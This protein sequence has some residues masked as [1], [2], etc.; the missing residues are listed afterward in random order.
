[1]KNKSFIK[2]IV[3][4]ILKNILE[5]IVLLLSLLILLPLYMLVVNSF[6]DKA[7]AGNMSLALPKVWD[8]IDNYKQVFE[9]GGLLNAFK[10][11]A[12]I[13]IISIV[14]IV[15]ISSIS[16]FIIQRRKSFFTEAI[17]VIIMIIMVIPV[18]IVTVFFVVMQ[19]HLSGTYIGVSL[20]YATTFIP[21]AIFL[22]VG[23]FKS[24]PREIDES[25]WLDGC[26]QIRLFY[27]LIFPLAQPVTVTVIIISFM[28]IWND[29]S[30]VIYMFD[31]PQK[32]TVVLTTFFFYSQYISSWNLVFAD[33][34]LV[35]LPI[36]I[37]Y[38]FLQKYI[39][40][41]MVAGAVKG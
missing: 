34:V 13:S 24:I 38:L 6:K 15:V 8:I 18:A 14:L 10:N 17:N 33:L 25:G 21:L 22:Y 37:V 36:V 20:V 12:I 40:S 30:V 5:L 27:Q 35:S 41:G 1:M 7:D 23:Y 32:Y 16:A 26:G 11:S 39:I 9:L 4:W 19:L 3:K 28:S 29:F 31:D 2:K